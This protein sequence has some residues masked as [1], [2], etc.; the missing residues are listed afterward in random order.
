MTRFA[1][2]VLLFAAAAPLTMA[3]PISVNL[4]SV[5][6]NGSNFTWTY[7]VAMAAGENFQISAPEDF[8]EILDFAGYVPGTAAI[9]L[10]GGVDFTFSYPTHS[11]IPRTGPPP[12]HAD[13]LPGGLDDPRVGNLLFTHTGPTAFAGPQTF[14]ISAD[15]TFSST[16]S[17]NFVAQLR[18]ITGPT[19]GFLSE[20]GP[21]TVPV[22]GAAVPEASTFSLGIG[23]VLL[24]VPLIL[25]RRRSAS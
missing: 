24:G 7:T 9:D 5:V 22:A 3:N 6:A 14:H 20:R 8:L 25:R 1:I 15:S 13:P 23:A 2:G 4:T 17:D 21:A 12:G 11:P 10:G 16:A 19:N 18:D